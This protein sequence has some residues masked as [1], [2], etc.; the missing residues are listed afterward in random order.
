M[1][2]CMHRFVMEVRFRALRIIVQDAEFQP[3]YLCLDHRAEGSQVSH[4]PSACSLSLRRLS[5]V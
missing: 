1:S 3:G 2:V 4:C 5:I